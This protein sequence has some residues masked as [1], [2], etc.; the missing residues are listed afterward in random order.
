MLP[1]QITF[2]HNISENVCYLAS[3]L[4]ENLD[5]AVLENVHSLLLSISL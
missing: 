4:F 3:V 1:S 2:L 5:V